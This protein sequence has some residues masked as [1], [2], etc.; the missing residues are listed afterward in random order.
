MHVFNIAEYVSSVLSLSVTEMTVFRSRSMSASS[1]LC[2]RPCL[3]LKRKKQFS[4][5]SNILLCEDGNIV[6]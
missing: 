6:I 1:S 3:Y 4:V 5:L 2:L